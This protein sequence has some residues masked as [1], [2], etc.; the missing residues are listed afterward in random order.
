VSELSCYGTGSS[1]SRTRRQVGKTSRWAE[2]RSRPSVNYFRAVD[3]KM[4]DE[5]LEV[6]ISSEPISCGSI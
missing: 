4:R 1:D 5:V 2:A 3:D 6:K